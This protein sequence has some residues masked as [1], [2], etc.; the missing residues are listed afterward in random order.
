[1]SS[2]IVCIH[3]GENLKSQT[4]CIYCI[5]TKFNH[6]NLLLA[7]TYGK[8]TVWRNCQSG[9]PGWLLSWALWSNGTSTCKVSRQDWCATLTAVPST[10]IGNGTSTHK[11]PI[12]DF[13]S[14]LHWNGWVKE[15]PSSWRSFSDELSTLDDLKFCRFLE[16]HLHEHEHEL[17]Q[18]TL[19][20]VM[21]QY[22]QVTSTEKYASLH[23]YILNEQGSPVEIN[24]FYG[25]WHYVVFDVCGSVHHYSFNKQP[26]WCSL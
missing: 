26:T 7:G 2:D 11:F 20:L 13:I 15:L 14:I 9:V 25:M 4:L 16:T 21:M 23:L 10:L 5:S 19:L 24:F 18:Y 22:L 12:Q 17:F 3:H 1:M 8:L 6:V